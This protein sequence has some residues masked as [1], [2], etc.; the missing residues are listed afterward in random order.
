MKPAQERLAVDLRAL[1]VRD[2]QFP[3]VAN[4]DAKPKTDAAGA[5]AA[6]I[7]QVSA[8]VQ[9]QAVV[10]RLI[11]EGG[12]TFVELGPG[13]VLAGLIKKIDREVTAMSI[14]DDRTFAAALPQLAAAR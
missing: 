12:T 10:R 11:A 3:V 1:R 2:P 6:L 7:E 9:W 14:M 13:T 8:P 5:I 4:A